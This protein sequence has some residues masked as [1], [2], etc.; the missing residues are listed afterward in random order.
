MAVHASSDPTD[1]FKLLTAD[2]ASELIRLPRS[3]V[4]ELV[5]NQRIPFVR[6]GRRIFFVRAALIQWITEQVTMPRRPAAGAVRRDETLG[7]R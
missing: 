1:E 7:H 6:I 3:S 4:Y 2:E 5:R